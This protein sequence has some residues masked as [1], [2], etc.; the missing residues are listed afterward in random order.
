[1]DKSIFLIDDD[2]I[3][4]FILKQY[5]QKENLHENLITAQNGKV[6]YEMLEEMSN[7]DKPLPDLIILDINMPVWDGWTFLEA[8]QKLENSDKIKLYILSSSDSPS[9]LDIAA[10]FGLENNYLVKPITQEKVSE[11]VNNI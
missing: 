7:S 11:I 4:V 3:Q 6:A 8:F 5:L 2:L 9:D 10:K 1:M